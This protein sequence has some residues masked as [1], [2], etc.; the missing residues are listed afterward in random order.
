M[1]KVWILV[2]REYKAAV[3]TKGFIISLVMLPIMMGGGFAAFMLLKDKVDLTDK[4]V[5]IIDESGSVGNH[6]IKVANERNAN[7]ITDEETGEKIQPAYNLEIIPVESDITG[8]HSGTSGIV[9][10]S[11][12]FQIW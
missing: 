2:K 11:W 5:M 8:I 3:R 12:L 1:N 7:Y 6:L 10:K 4:R 9:H